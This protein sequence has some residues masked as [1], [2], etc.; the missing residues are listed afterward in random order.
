MPATR[1]TGHFSPA[2]NRRNDYN[3]YAATAYNYNRCNDNNNNNNNNNDNDDNDDDNNGINNDQPTWRSSTIDL[4]ARK[5]LPA[6]FRQRL[7]F[8]HR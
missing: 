4:P 5:A 7:Y 6:F 3:D 8:H 2:L 1:S